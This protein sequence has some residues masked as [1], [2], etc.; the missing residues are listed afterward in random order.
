MPPTLRWIG[1]AWVNA[2]TSAPLINMPMPTLLLANPITVPHWSGYQLP[3]KEINGVKVK[4][5]PNPSNTIHI[6]NKP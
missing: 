5:V 3:N 2:G 1:L 6:I 4:A